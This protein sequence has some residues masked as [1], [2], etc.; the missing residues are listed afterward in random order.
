MKTCGEA[1]LK[2]PAT[3]LLLVRALHYFFIDDKSQTMF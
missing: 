1:A 2:L 3:T